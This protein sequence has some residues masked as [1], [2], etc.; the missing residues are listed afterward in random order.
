MKLFISS[1]DDKGSRASLA[2]ERVLRDLAP[3][4]ELFRHE[5][6]HEYVFERSESLDSVQ[7]FIRK[8]DLLVVCASRGSISSQQGLEVGF[9][10][11][12]RS[13]QGSDYSKNIV[14]WLLD[15]D[16]STIDQRFQMLRSDPSSLYNFL[17][18]IC[19]FE[20]QDFHARALIEAAV[21]RLESELAQLRPVS[22]RKLPRSSKELATDIRSAA[23]SANRHLLQ[24]LR[25]EAAEQNASDPRVLRN[26]LDAYRQLSDHYGVIS[27]F[28]QFSSITIDDPVAISRYAFALLRTKQREKAI[29]VLEDAIGKGHDE[30]ELQGLL[31]RA[32]K[33]MWVEKSN[34]GNDPSADDDLRRSANAYF[35]AFKKNSRDIYIGMNAIVTL[36]LLGDDRSLSLRDEIIPLVRQRFAETSKADAA[37]YWNLSSRLELAT[38]MQDR[39]GAFECVALLRESMVAGSSERWQIETTSESLKRIGRARG[40]KNSAPT[41][42]SEVTSM[43]EAAA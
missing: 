6:R 32:Y 4:I 1:S 19:R 39:D 42:L 8:A 5:I 33:D 10:M 35:E 12:S 22:P 36:H 29:E 26:F 9:F 2:L 3:S 23:T 7:N 16:I 34:W 21:S 18:W 38:I 28:E 17:Q 41:W 43:L 24:I 14:F 30:A 15:A 31:G 27:V 37:D 13:K 11:G 40:F 20:E 25:Q